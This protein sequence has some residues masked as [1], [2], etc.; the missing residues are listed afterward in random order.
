MPIF[1]NVKM[2]KITVKIAGPSEHLR[3]SEKSTEWIIPSF[4]KKFKRKLNQPYKKNMGLR[5][6]AKFKKLKIKAFKPIFLNMV[7]LMHH[8][9]KILSKK[10]EKLVWK[11]MALKM[12]FNQRKSKKR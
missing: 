3:L 7:L 4:L 12:S 8:K 11:D 2:E 10:C 9:T 1:Q 5:I 6:L